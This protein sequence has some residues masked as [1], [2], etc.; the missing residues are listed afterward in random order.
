[1]DKGKKRQERGYP[2]PTG[3]QPPNGISIN[4]TVFTGLMNV[5]NRQTTLLRM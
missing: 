4:S 5:T 3:G 2:G 1:M